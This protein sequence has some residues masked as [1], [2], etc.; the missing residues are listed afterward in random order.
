MKWTIC[1]AT[2]PWREAELKRLMDN[3]IPQV[4]KY[5]DVEILIFFNNFEWSLGFLRQCLIEEAKGEYV[6]HVDDDD[7]VPEDYVDT[8][9]PL[10]DGVDYIGF[11]VKFIDNGKLMSPVYHSLKYTHWHQDDKGYYRGVTHLNPIKTQLA[12]KAGF[13]IERQVGEDEKWAQ[14]VKAKTEHF[15]DREMYTYNH[16]GDDSVA[17]KYVEELHDKLH[18]QETKPRPHDTP[19]RPVFKSKNVRFHPRSTK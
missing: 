14:K 16:M 4:E 6:C 1:I 9:Y 2:N 12:L 3:L 10:L 11:K 7:E 5:Q 18:N 17:Y 13:P 15:I 19:V 8:I